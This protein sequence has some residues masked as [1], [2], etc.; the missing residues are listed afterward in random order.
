[1]SENEFDPIT[2]AEWY[3]SSPAKCKKCGERIECI[4]VIK[5][6]PL[7]VGSVIKYVWR[8]GLKSGDTGGLDKK[9]K[10]LKQASYYIDQAILMAEQEIKEQDPEPEMF[11]YRPVA[12]FEVE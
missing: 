2:K 9:L 6:M 10:D 3:N 8:H 1:M 7:P 5:H 12:D 11:T 4:D